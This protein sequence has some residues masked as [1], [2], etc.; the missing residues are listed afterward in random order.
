MTISFTCVVHYGYFIL[1]DEFD[2]DLPPLASSSEYGDSLVDVS[3]ECVSIQ[4]TDLNDECCTAVSSTLEIRT[5]LSIT[6]AE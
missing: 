2:C 6:V 5:E 3:E 1:S 4:S